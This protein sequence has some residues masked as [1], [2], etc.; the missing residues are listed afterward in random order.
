MFYWFWSWKALSSLIC[1][2]LSVQS[3]LCVS[4]FTTT[5]HVLT[6]TEGKK[7]FF[8]CGNKRRELFFKPSEDICAHTIILFNIYKSSGILCIQ[9][10]RW[11]RDLKSCNEPVRKQPFPYVMSSDWSLTSRKIEISATLYAD[12]CVCPP[13]A[14]LCSRSQLCGRSTY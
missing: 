10:N 8:L 9:N 6:F 1:T 3:D 5:H 14:K 4:E 11:I 12:I 13:V 2:R 7:C